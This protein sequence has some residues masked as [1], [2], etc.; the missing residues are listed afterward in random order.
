MTGRLSIV[1]PVLNEQA[2]IAATLTR[3]ARDFGD[4]EIVVVDG[5]STDGT[6]ETATTTIAAEL[7][8]P[9]V[10]V[11]RGP[12]GRA[13]QMNTGAAH[14]T[15]DVLWFVHADTRIDPT[16]E[17]QIRAALVDPAVVGGGLTLRF[18]RAGPALRYLAWTSNQR[19]RR[20][21]W[22]FGD[23]AMFVRREVFHAIGGF[24]GLPIMEDLEASRRLAH[25]GQLVVLAATCTASARRFDQHG[26]WRMLV[27]MQWLKALHFAGVDAGEI[28]RRYTAGPR[29]WPGARPPCAIAVG[30]RG[31]CPDTRAKENARVV[32]D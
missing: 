14:A 18:D 30:D 27:F 24:P 8:R 11:I 29:R 6:V 26:T 15:G 1:I 5:G 13:R 22:I 3:L 4:C 31:W 23:Q 17:Q 19:A 21:H 20:L 28:A 7:G 16:A 12:R 10:R 32:T 25:Q 9:T 2:Y